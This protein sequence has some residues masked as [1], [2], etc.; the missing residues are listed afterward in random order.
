MRSAPP[1]L[2]LGPAARPG[3]GTGADASALAPGLGAAACAAT[4]EG[5][6]LGRGFEAV[7]Q[8]LERL[9]LRLD[10]W[11]DQ[12][13]RRLEQ[14]LRGRRSCRPQELSG[15]LLRKQCSSTGRS[16][17]K[18]SV[19][20]CGEEQPEREQ[21]PFQDNCHDGAEEQ[22]WRNCVSRRDPAA[23]GQTSCQ[24]G[25]RWRSSQEGE[26]L[27]IVPQSHEHNKRNSAQ[28]LL[29]RGI[30]RSPTCEARGCFK[31]RGNF[32]LPPCS[33]LAVVTHPV[34]DLFF[35]CMIVLNS[36]FIGFQTEYRMR[37]IGQTPQPSAFPA[38]E[39]AFV[40]AFTV[41]LAV[42]MLALK[43]SFFSPK[44]MWW[45]LFDLAL[46]VMS[47]VE[48]AL[49]GSTSGGDAPEGGGKVI[50]MF[51][52]AR[53]FRIV[54]VLRF[55]AEL[56]IMVLLIVHSVRS[57]FWLMVLLCLI[58]YVFSV[59]FTQGV[60][61]HL[62]SGGSVAAEEE[63]RLYYGGLGTSALTLFTSITGGVSWSEVLQP[64]EA[65]GW[66]FTALF[67]A[68]VS[69]CVFSV[70]NIVTGVFVDGA[71]QRSAQERDLRLEKEKEQKK[72]YVSMLMDLLEEIDS[73]GTG[74]ITREELAEA[75]KSE[76]VRYSF[77][78]LDIDISDSN[79]LFDMLDLDRSGEVDMDEFVSGCLRLKGNA[80]SIDIH[81]LMLEI[82]HL[83]RKWEAFIDGPQAPEELV[84]SF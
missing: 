23:S 58:L 44:S 67:I 83:M 73:A 25:A 2:G 49:E 17:E 81:T 47:L 22:E 31:F 52:M 19:Q 35:A 43:A 28:F 56:R 13:Q 6:A 80:K 51:R 74:V 27:D 29:L 36:L 45:N 79:Y 1:G 65:V 32:Q 40:A 15:S 82:R 18:L 64:L 59:F 39:K 24:S 70:L 62:S 30:L 26:E 38:I 14:A 68:F 76:K 33:L 54:R 75:F 9:E 50:R 71:I 37:T 48:L 55:L 42:R 4:C 53:V 63:L 60:T 69:F 84:M 34:F 72:V 41:E 61:D 11:N 57:L 66:P 20:P 21:S 46:V 78:V 3:A 77:S 10:E 12:Q 7:L 8:R 16:V 5:A